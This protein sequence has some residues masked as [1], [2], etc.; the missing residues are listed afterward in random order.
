MYEDRTVVGYTVKCTKIIFHQNQ[1]EIFLYLYWCFFF[2]VVPNTG[3]FNSPSTKDTK[4]W[5]YWYIYV[6]G[7]LRNQSSPEPVTY[8]NDIPFSTWTCRRSHRVVPWVTSILM[9]LKVLCDSPSSGRQSSVIEVDRATPQTVDAV[10]EQLAAE[11]WL[12]VL[13]HCSHQKLFPCQCNTEQRRNQR[14]LSIQ[15]IK[16]INPPANYILRLIPTNE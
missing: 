7:R 16:I 10:E 2:C 14:V 11:A 12:L 15:L 9:A 4:T 6:L 5:T 3:L 8:W 1:F 13:Q